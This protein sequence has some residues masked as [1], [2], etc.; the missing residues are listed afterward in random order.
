M[1]SCI[2]FCE[3][4]TRYDQTF[5]SCNI[6][7]VK[8]VFICFVNA[9]LSLRQIQ[10]DLNTYSGSFELNVSCY[11]ICDLYFLFSVVPEIRGNG[12]TIPVIIRSTTWS[13]RAKKQDFNNVNKFTLKRFNALTFRLAAFLF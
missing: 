2:L 4:V 7:Q 1:K 8:W 3:S 13:A 11:D 12:K 6:H 10:S 9:N 5:M